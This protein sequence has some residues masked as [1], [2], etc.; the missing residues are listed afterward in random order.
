MLLEA[1]FGGAATLSANGGETLALDLLFLQL[2][3][4]YD[5]GGRLVGIDLG[6]LHLNL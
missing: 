6:P 4:D 5:A 1:L 2:G 3:L